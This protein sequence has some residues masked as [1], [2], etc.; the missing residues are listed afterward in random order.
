MFKKSTSD[1]IYGFIKKI[2]VENSAFKLKVEKEKTITD[3][4]QLYGYSS[5]NY[6]SVFKKHFN[7][8]HLLKLS[9]LFDVDVCEFLKVKK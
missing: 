8:T 2:K 1:S 5:S 6:S 7:L 4:G 3:I 9:I